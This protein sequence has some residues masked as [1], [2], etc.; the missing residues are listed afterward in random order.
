MLGADIET[1]KDSAHVRESM[2]NK[3]DAI[4]QKFEW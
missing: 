2:K 1:I 4:L 3:V